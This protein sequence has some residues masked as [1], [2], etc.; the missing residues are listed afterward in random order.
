[1]LA[2][3]LMLPLLLDETAAAARLSEL[4]AGFAGRPKSDSM[5]ALVQLADDAPD[6]AAGARALDWLGDLYRGDHDRA[7]AQAVYE[8][9][10][11]TR[12]VEA[13]RLAARGLGDLA[14]EAGGYRRAQT[15]YGE[16]RSGAT[17]VLFVELGEKINLARTLERRRAAEWGAWALV[18][19]SLAYF[20]ARSRFWRK[21]WPE[22]PTE[23]LYVVPVYIL[24]VG[25]CI[26][27]DPAVLHALWLC[28]LWSIAL[29]FAAGLA[30]RR[31]LPGR[32]GRAAHATLLAVANGALFYAV[33][34]RAGLLESLFM[35]V[36]P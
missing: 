7:R 2:V 35:T 26:G 22:L 19:A 23:A 36:A 6:T 3:L 21:P 17:G 5:A 12:D 14:V 20:L 15:L 1:M 4:R 28:A 18:L 25:G 27:R 9:A 31:V 29:I 16:A 11:R 32:A 13:R 24:L 8:R 30:A 10:Y 34:N 33:C